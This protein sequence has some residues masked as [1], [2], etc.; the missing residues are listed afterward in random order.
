MMVSTLYQKLQITD[1]IPTEY[2][3]ITNIINRYAELNDVYAVLYSM[4][5]LVHPVLQKDNYTNQS[6]SPIGEHVNKFIN[7]LSSALALA[8][9][10]VQHL[11]DAWN[12]FD[13]TVPEVLKITVL[14]NTMECSMN[15]ETGNVSL[16]YIKKR[17]DAI[18]TQTKAGGPLDHLNMRHWIHTATSH[19][20]LQIHGKTS[21]SK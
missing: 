18:N 9:S 5:E 19:D 3:S 1:D 10:R 20:I 2:T 12:L 11:L 13:H 7:E 4:L 16:G 15:E 6:Y 21:N 14:P 17:T 8:V